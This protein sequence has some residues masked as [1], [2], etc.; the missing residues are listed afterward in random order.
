MHEF[1]YFENQML[2]GLTTKCHQ[3]RSLFQEYNNYSWI[4]TFS[5]GILSTVF[6][7]D[8]TKMTTVIK[9]FLKIT[10][11]FKSGWKLF[12]TLWTFTLHCTKRN[13]SSFPFYLQSIW[14]LNK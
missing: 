3:T 9:S 6:S 10:Y 11:E 5:G 1:K 14:Q 2:S 7:V 8:I 13:S 12:L 4:R